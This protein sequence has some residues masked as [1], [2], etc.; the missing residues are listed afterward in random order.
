MIYYIDSNYDGGTGMNE[1]NSNGNGLVEDNEAV[2]KNE[3]TD[4]TNTIEKNKTAKK[5]KN[6]LLTVI[7]SMIALLILAGFVLWGIANISGKSNLYNKASSEGPI[8][9]GIQSEET[10]NVESEK[11]IT[12][13][14]GWIRY[15]DEIYQYNEDILT[16]L[17]MGIDKTSE[18]KVLE[19]GVDGGQA[20]LIMLAVFNPHTKTTSLITIN[21]NTMT[22]IDVYDENGDY[23]GSG[24]G[25]ICL[26]HGYGDGATLSCERM[27]KAVSNLFY[28][29][30]IHG[31][32]SINMGA[33]KAIN[34][35]VD[36]VTMTLDED[37]KASLDGVSVSIPKGEHTFT[38]DE[39]HVYIRY[40]DHAEFD[41]ATTRLNREKKYMAAFL[42][43]LK[44]ETAKDITVP[45]KVYNELSP[46]IV[47]DINTSE[48]TYMVSNT[49]N[50]KF[51]FNNI[52]S[53]EGTTVIGKTEHEEF[54]Y[55]PDHLYDMI[56][57][58]FYEKVY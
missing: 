14:K 21:R 24:E 54:N 23:V 6:L 47:T 31:Y 51:D 34:S 49:H 27:E 25:Q 41:S 16:F 11:D 42:S 9:E 38:D 8:L 7:F 46:Y 19:S 55:D 22:T 57:K 56:I 37:F 12:W 30:P 4:V 36:G 5:K 13:K 28:N 2:S 17:V 20:D 50:Y 35:A 18:V 48:M 33:I 58:I 15:N 44:E 40:R 26:Q 1:G 52:Y 43:K 29:L 39:A 53:L 3:A 32:I 10:S 45:L